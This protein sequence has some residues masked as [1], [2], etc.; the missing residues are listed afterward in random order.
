MDHGIDGV[1]VEDTVDE[2]DVAEI[3]LLEC[4]PLAP[5]SG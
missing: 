1:V 5:P 4:A 2:R 3:A